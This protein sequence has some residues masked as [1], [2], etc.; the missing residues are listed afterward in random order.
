MATYRLLLQYYKRLLLRV[1]GDAWSFIYDKYPWQFLLLVAAAIAVAALD[2]IAGHER[3]TAALAEPR[4]NAAVESLARSALTLIAVAALIFIWNLIVAPAKIDQERQKEISRLRQQV[5]PGPPDAKSRVQD[6]LRNLFDVYLELQLVSNRTNE[7]VWNA[8]S[9]RLD[10]Y[11]A[12]YSLLPPTARRFH[13]RSAPA[14]T[15]MILEREFDRL[16]EC[17]DDASDIMLHGECEL[18]LTISQPTPIMVTN[19][20]AR[21]DRFIV[22]NL[23]IGNREDKAVSLFPRWHW[24]LDPGRVHAVYQA[25]AEPLKDYEENRLRIP[26]PATPSLAMPLTLQ[27]H[28]AATG[29]W[30]FFIGK[31]L[32]NNKRLKDGRKRVETVLEILDFASGRRTKS[33]R[34]YLDIE[35]I[36]TLLEPLP[37]PENNEFLI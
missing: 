35:L 8:F 28:G 9:W 2:F 25:D 33:E 14:L 18:D 21:R 17:M 15:H 26:K 24:Y 19:R 5:A 20:E 36:R 13:E 1:L 34:F 32:E 4:L 37:P 3:T 16:S 27:P 12:A 7:D 30:C 6:A 11:K 29:Y 31:D 10:E 23:I 22:L